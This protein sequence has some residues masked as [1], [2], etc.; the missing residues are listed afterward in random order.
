MANALMIAFGKAKKGHGA[1]DGD[2]PAGS[3]DEGEGSHEDVATSDEET[4][5]FSELKAALKSGDDET[6]A[7]A[8]KNFIQICKG[9]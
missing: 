2:E 6:G 4:K 5:A 1:G 9:Y 7:M 8:L 3:S